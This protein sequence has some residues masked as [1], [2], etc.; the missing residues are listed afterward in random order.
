MRSRTWNIPKTMQHGFPSAAI[1]SSDKILT[2][3]LAHFVAD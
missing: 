2:V 1:I 3:I